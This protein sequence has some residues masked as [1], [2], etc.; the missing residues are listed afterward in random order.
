M[1]PYLNPDEN[2][3]YFGALKHALDALEYAWCVCVCVCVFG[4]RSSG[5]PHV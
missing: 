3:S 4:M 1:N 5:V 2:G